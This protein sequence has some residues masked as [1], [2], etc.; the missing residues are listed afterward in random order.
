MALWSA[1]R[2]DQVLPQRARECQA[3]RGL[4]KSII[5]DQAECY[6]FC[7][8][9]DVTV[10]AGCGVLPIV[11]RNCGVAER[12]VDQVHCLKIDRTA[13]DL[14]KAMASIVSG[15]IDLDKLAARAAGMVDVAKRYYRAL[16]G[17]AVGGEAQRP[18]LAEA[19]SFLSQN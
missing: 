16:T 18:E 12:L 1:D 9:E 10:A 19:R 2:S 14:A 5:S 8:K 3:P 11:T 6:V 7:G 13:A 17:L 15:T 4:S